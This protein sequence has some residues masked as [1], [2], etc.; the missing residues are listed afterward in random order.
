MRKDSYTAVGLI[1]FFPP[2]HTLAPKIKSTI[3]YKV[4][5]LCFEI[6]Q[7][8]RYHRQK[9][10]ILSFK[11]TKVSEKNVHSLNVFILS[12]EVLKSRTVQP[13]VMNCS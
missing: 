9:Y 5:N 13:K 7:V 2:N 10:I 1:H 3:A 11:I 12:K 4:F 6:F 8:E